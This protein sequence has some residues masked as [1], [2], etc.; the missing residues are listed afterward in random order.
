MKK[1]NLQKDVE[2]AIVPGRVRRP[3]A[4]RVIEP[5][6]VQ[7]ATLT[8]FGHS[9]LYLAAPGGGEHQPS[10]APSRTENVFRLAKPQTRRKRDVTFTVEYMSVEPRQVLM[11]WSDYEQM[12]AAQQRADREKRRQ[13]IANEG[14]RDAEMDAASEYLR[15]LGLTIPEDF[16]ALIDPRT[17]FGWTVILRPEAFEKLKAHLQAGATTTGETR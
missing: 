10:Y 17:S 15:S 16:N 11:P 7:R 8:R 13:Q 12:E 4:G 5:A 3:A 2:Y 9:V 14:R 6:Y 1:D